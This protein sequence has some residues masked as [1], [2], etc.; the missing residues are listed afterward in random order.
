M[1]LLWLAHGNMSKFDLA[2]GVG[3]RLF[4]AIWTHSFGIP[5][6]FGFSGTLNVGT[7]ARR[8]IQRENQLLLDYETTIVVTRLLLHAH[9]LTTVRVVV[10]MFDNS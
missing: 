7:V 2:I 5:F 4:T 6:L 8:C 1:V 10:S 3:T 9:I